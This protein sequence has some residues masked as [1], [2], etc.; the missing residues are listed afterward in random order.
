[1]NWL[2]KLFGRKEISMSKFI[3]MESTPLEYVI[4]DSNGVKGCVSK[5]KLFTYRYKEQVSN[6]LSMEG[7]I[8][9]LLD[10]Y[11]NDKPECLQIE[12]IFYT[13]K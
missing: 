2:K 10:I 3:I 12:V 8:C 6:P 9:A 7:C 4:P 5:F 1:M 13:G 11:K